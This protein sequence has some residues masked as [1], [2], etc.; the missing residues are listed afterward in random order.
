MTADQSSIFPFP[1][2]MKIQWDAEW[3]SAARRKH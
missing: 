1:T 3:A 2:T